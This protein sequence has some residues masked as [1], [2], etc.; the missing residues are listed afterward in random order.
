[1]KNMTKKQRLLNILIDNEYDLNGN[2]NFLLKLSNDDLNKF[3][4]ENIFDVHD[5][6]TI[7]L[8]EDNETIL[9][10]FNNKI[11]TWI[12]RYENENIDGLTRVAIVN[13]LGN[14]YPMLK[15]GGKNYMNNSNVKEWLK[16][17]LKEW[18]RQINDQQE[19]N[20]NQQENKGVFNKLFDYFS[21]PKNKKQDD[22]ARPPTPP[23]FELETPIRNEEEKEPEQPKTEK[24]YKYNDVFKNK[25]KY[26]KLNKLNEQ[27]GKIF[28]GSPKK[29]Y[30]ETYT[31]DLDKFNDIVKI[32]GLYKNNSI[33]IVKEL[34]EEFNDYKSNN[35]HA[36][37]RKH[38]NKRH[39]STKNINLVELKRLM[40]NI[41]HR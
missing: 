9:D 14:D 26:D 37:G 30:K 10:K 19:N 38:K 24:T 22:H 12:D 29:I 3:I 15:K 8:S 32:K 6:E 23:K 40:K 13:D 36:Q 16:K 39:K 20:N 33:P 27:Y 7:H 17:E 35:Q 34:L 5:G 1:M 25:E 41:K 31:N 11:R 2:F 4:N 18:K 28:K 21:P